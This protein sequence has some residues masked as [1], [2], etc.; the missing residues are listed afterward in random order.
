MKL[1]PMASEDEMASA[2]PMYLSGNQHRRTTSSVWTKAAPTCH[3]PYWQSCPAL[4]VLQCRRPKK[5]K[6]E[7]ALYTGAAVQVRH[8]VGRVTAG[9]MR[10]SRGGSTGVLAVRMPLRYVQQGASSVQSQAHSDI[11]CRERG[12]RGEET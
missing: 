5:L 8:P 9:E 11:R 1:V 6:S 7:N 12:C 3:R 10:R 4:P 2:R